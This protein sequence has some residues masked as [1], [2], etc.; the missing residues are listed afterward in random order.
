MTH[1]GPFQPLLFCDSVILWVVFVAVAER[2]APELRNGPGL[3]LQPALGGVQLMGC[4][5]CFWTPPAQA[6]AGGWTEASQTRSWGGGRA[7][8]VPV[9]AGS[10]QGAQSS[11]VVQG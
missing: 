4:V 3:A 9:G 11:R 1:R 7:E 8:E 2:N 6:P 10:S 5:W